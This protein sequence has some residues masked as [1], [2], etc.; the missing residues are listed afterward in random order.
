MTGVDETSQAKGQQVANSEK[1]G[2][3]TRK[4]WPQIG[5]VRFEKKHA[6][7]CHVSLPLRQLVGTGQAMLPKVAIQQPQKLVIDHADG[8][9]FLIWHPIVELVISD[10]GAN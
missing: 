8:G 3:T 7:N 4:M 6:A 2:P 1:R 9:V 5:K 10:A